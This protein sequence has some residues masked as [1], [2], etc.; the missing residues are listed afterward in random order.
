MRPMTVDLT[1]TSTILNQARSQIGIH[2]RDRVRSVRPNLDHI[3]QSWCVNDLIP[4]RLAEARPQASDDLRFEAAH[5]IRRFLS[6]PTMKLLRKA[7]ADYPTPGALHPRKAS[8]GRSKGD[9]DNQAGHGGKGDGHGD[10]TSNRT[11]RTIATVLSV[12]TDHLYGS[13]EHRLA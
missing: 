12:A 13:A 6:Q 5:V 9:P 7:N 2:N 3:L 4:I 10:T 8:D 1:T 11:K